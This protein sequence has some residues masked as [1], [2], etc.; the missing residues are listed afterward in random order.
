[1]LTLTLMDEECRGTDSTPE[2]VQSTSVIQVLA[3]SSAVK[4]HLTQT[5]SAQVCV[6][7]YLCMCMCVRVCM[8]GIKELNDTGWFWRT[9]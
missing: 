6:C 2:E 9:K 3:P 4:D 8:R 7:V 5:G 1:M